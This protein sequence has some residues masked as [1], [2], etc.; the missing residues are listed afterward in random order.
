[1]VIV[2]NLLLN[3]DNVLFGVYCTQKMVFT[4]CSFD[5][6]EPTIQTRT[7]ELFRTSSIQTNYFKK[8]HTGHELLVKIKAG[9]LILKLELY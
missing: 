1:M 5:R 6:T 8:I 7:S 3:V 9:K 2:K 4:K